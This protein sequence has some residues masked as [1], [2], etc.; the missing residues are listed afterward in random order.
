MPKAMTAD[1]LVIGCG[2]GGAVT[3]TMC[4][5]AG[6]DVLVIEDGGDL[7]LE[8]APHFSRDEILQKYRN[9]GVSVAFGNAKIVYAEGRVV[10][11]GS[12]INR[13]L[14]HRLGDD[15]RERWIK[16][17]GVQNLGGEELL[18]HFEACEQTAKVEFLPGEAPKLSTRLAEGADALNWSSMEVP[19]LFSYASNWSSGG[20]PGRKQSMSETFVP[21]YRDAGGR[22]IDYTR[23][24]KI[25]RSGGKWRVK[26]TRSAPGQDRE[27]VEIS[28]QNVFVACGPVHTPALLRRSG[29]RKNVGNTL[30]F[31]PMIRTVA[32][33]EDELNGPNQLEPVHQIKHFDPAFS[34]G[35]SMS[36]RPALAMAMSHFP[37]LLSEVDRNWRNMAIYYVQNT[38][39]IATVRN[40]PGIQDPFVRVHQSK[41][42]LTEL[43]EGVARLAE[44]LFAAGALEVYP[45]LPGYP[46]LRSMDDVVKLPKTI[47]PQ[48]ASTTVL[49][50]FSSVPMG[51]NPD[52]CATDSFG[53]LPDAD[54]LRVAD[55]SLLC[56]PTV[57]NPQ[58]SVMAV[59][60]R[61]VQQFLESR[62]R[63]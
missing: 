23:A 45:G 15:V 61:N 43:A 8:S 14:Y 37:E 32:L 52:L 38:G 3:A 1:V 28:A 57:V 26:A 22:L 50:M 59:A 47:A 48:R 17:Y 10:G 51:E 27:H 36:N 2:P 19:R 25:T 60:H 42:D 33:F 55:A 40:L 5:E 39:G 54:G 24:D 56:T 11:G 18:P 58:G 53:R 12:E 7:P 62:S 31:H 30:R 34:I 13:G 20:S 46:I 41:H 16:E 29:I 44:V 63:V 49:H 4:Q 35:C 6:L 21:R 9:A